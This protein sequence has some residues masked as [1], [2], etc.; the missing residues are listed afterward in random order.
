MT[1]PI[2]E[3]RTPKWLSWLLGLFLVALVAP[4]AWSVLDVRDASRYRSIDL[5]GPL[6]VSRE[7]VTIVRDDPTGI[8]SILETL[9]DW[10]GQ[11]IDVDMLLEATEAPEVGL[12]QADVRRVF[13]SAGL[14]A[15][16]FTTDVGSLV[17]LKRP[18]VAAVSE[19][20]VRLVLVRDIRQGLFY[21]F[22]PRVGNVIMEADDF[23][24]MYTGNA[25]A[26]EDPPSPETDVRVDPRVNASVNPGVNPTVDASIEPGVDADSSP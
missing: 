16:W 4:T 12:G 20:I 5:D 7:G 9:L 3:S 10:R 6:Y 1:V 18:L 8:R 19:D 2:E 22:D 21:L 17:R 23:G 14:E 25:L 26:F 13:G 24:E 15:Q 11:A